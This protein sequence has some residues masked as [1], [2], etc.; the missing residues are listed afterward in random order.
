MFNQASFHW[1]HSGGSIEDIRERKLELWCDEPIPMLNGETPRAASK[2]DA[3]RKKLDQ[4][5]DYYDSMR[6][7][8]P[9]GIDLNPTREFVEEKLQLKKLSTEKDI[10]LPNVPEIG[11]YVFMVGLDELEHNG[12]AGTVVGALRY[13]CLSIRM[14][15]GELIRVKPRNISLDSSYVTS[16]S[17]SYSRNIGNKQKSQSSFESR[18]DKNISYVWGNRM[19]FDPLTCKIPRWPNDGIER[20]NAAY[21]SGNHDLFNHHQCPANK[22]KSN[23]QKA[24]E[25]L[26][27]GWPCDNSFEELNE[28][29]RHIFLYTPI[30]NY[31]E[32]AAKETF[33][34][35]TAIDYLFEHQGTSESIQAILL[36]AIGKKSVGKYKDRFPGLRSLFG[37]LARQ[38]LAT[39][40]T[41]ETLF[42]DAQHVRYLMWHVACTI[43]SPP[44]PES[45]AYLEWQDVL[46]KNSFEKLGRICAQCGGQGRLLICQC[47]LAMYCNT[48]CRDAHR[49]LHRPD[50]CR[51]LGLQVTERMLRNS[52]QERQ[53]RATIIFKEVETIEKGINA[54]E[55][56]DKEYILANF[57][58]GELKPWSQDA[59]DCQGQKYRTHIGE[60]YHELLT[61]VAKK[62]GGFKHKLEELKFLF[63][64]QGLPGTEIDNLFLFTKSNGHL[65]VILNFIRLFSD[66][67]DKGSSPLVGIHIDNCYIPIKKSNPSDPESHVQWAPV[68]RP[69]THGT[70]FEFFSQWLHKARDDTRAVENYGL[71]TSGSLSQPGHSILESETGGVQYRLAGPFTKIHLA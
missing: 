4:L 50:C 2:H 27:G 10:A 49:K 28:E 6:A 70:D 35:Q 24:Y 48:M 55:Q 30:L 68:P 19:S 36:K 12:K 26:C 57:E 32:T 33:A 56:R 46:E 64:I 60:W 69:K 22:K 40:A 38:N 47:K 8:G 20:V 25:T 44:H 66:K 41:L 67:P 29:S 18:Y 34:V 62:V 11:T 65:A 54:R 3:G 39:E 52:E 7:Q 43:A 17:P 58:S 61:H 14:Q 42:G 63:P 16:L 21:R 71:Y 5:L 1:L 59:Y 31:Q 23:R 13:G 45:P 53:E 9:I 15:S 37:A 51:A